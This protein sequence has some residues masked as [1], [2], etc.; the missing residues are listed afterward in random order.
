MIG[1]RFEKMEKFGRHPNLVPESRSP[2]VLRIKEKQTQKQV[3]LSTHLSS[4][5]AL[6]VE[7]EYEHLKLQL[8]R[9]H[10]TN[11]L[12]SR[13]HRTIHRSD[14]APPS[15]LY[16]SISSKHLVTSSNGLPTQHSDAAT[17]FSQMKKLQKKHHSCWDV[18]VDSVDGIEG[19]CTNKSKCHLHSSLKQ[20][21]SW[22]KIRNMVHWSPFVQKFKKNRYPWVQ[23]AGHQGK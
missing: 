10:I 3:T 18:G 9:L 13:H 20:R 16:R 15:H 7:L 12:A 8:D 11:P 21:T 22:R 14:S 17:F 19:T 4:E 6:D 1:A 23:L 2:A 5:Q